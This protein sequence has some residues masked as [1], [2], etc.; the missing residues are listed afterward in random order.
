[1][2]D[3][4]H[5]PWECVRLDEAGNWDVFPIASEGTIFQ[6]SR[7]LD[8]CHGYLSSTSA[9]HNVRTWAPRRCYVL[10]SVNSTRR[11]TSKIASWQACASFP[12]FRHIKLES[13]GVDRTAPRTHRIIPAQHCFC[14]FDALLLRT[15]VKTF[16]LG[17]RATR[18]ELQHQGWMI[19]VL[20]V[21]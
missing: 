20:I 6:V 21:R 16:H 1:M 19:E 2:M 11:E 4:P 12:L 7:R 3:E 17:T 15:W 5:P 14:S 9:F 8:L 18:G 13:L 10:R